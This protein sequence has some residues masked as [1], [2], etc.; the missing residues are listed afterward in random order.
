MVDYLDA[1]LKYPMDYSYSILNFTTVRFS[2]EVMPQQ[3]ATFDYGFM[4]ND[5]FAQRPFGLSI[6][7]Y[8]S[9]QNGNYYMNAVYNETVNI[10]EIDEGLDSQTCV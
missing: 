7:L 5:A 2:K 10:I 8:Y 1:S 9:D 4:L 3:Q 6:N